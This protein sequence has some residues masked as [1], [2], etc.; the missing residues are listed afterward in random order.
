MIYAVVLAGSSAFGLD[1]AGGVM[2]YLAEHD[3]GFNVD[4]TKVPLVCQSD[5]FDL[6][7]R[8]MSV[9]PD[10]EMGYAACVN[11]E[12]G[13]YGTGTCAT[14]GKLYGMDF[15]MKSGI[16]SYK[17]QIHDLQVGTIVAVSKCSWRYL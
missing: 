1:A 10:K 15:C 8:D 3:I 11:L 16:G 12:R 6:T 13:N 5:L 4:I 14:V 9:Y 7:V 2:R 17:V